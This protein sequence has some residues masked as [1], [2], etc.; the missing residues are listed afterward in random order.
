MRNIVALGLQS[1]LH[2]RVTNSGDG[3]I[4]VDA[5]LNGDLPAIVRFSTP[6]RTR[7]GLRYSIVPRARC[8]VFGVCGE[9]DFDATADLQDRKF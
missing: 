2:L 7:N 4:S 5:N 9:H 3:A 1:G 8:P 6:A